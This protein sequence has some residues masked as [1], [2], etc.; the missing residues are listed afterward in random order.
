MTIQEIN[1]DVKT[2][3]RF[4]EAQSVISIAQNKHKRPDPKAV[5]EILLLGSE[6]ENIR[7]RHHLRPNSFNIF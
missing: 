3:M 6:I 4:I 2:L 7:K 5:N 1:Q